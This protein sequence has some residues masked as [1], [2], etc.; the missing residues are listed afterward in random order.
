MHKFW[1]EYIDTFA[2]SAYSSRVDCSYDA[3]FLDRNDGYPKVGGI[4][5]NG[6][7]PAELG[8][9]QLGVSMATVFNKALKSF[10]APSNFAVSWVDD[11]ASMTWINKSGAAAVFKIWESKNGGEYTLVATTAAN[12]TSYNN[13]T[14]LN[15][16]MNFK[17]QAVN[18]A[19]ISDFSPVVNLATPLVIKSDQSILTTT[20]INAIEITVGKTVNINWDDGTNE[21]KTGPTSAT[22]NYSVEKNPYYIKLSGDTDSIT[23][24]SIVNQLKISCDISKWV[25]PLNLNYADLGGTNSTGN[26]EKLFSAPNLTYLKAD[27]NLT[28]DISKVVFSPSLTYIY[29]NQSLT[30]G[31]I[32]DA[33]NINLPVGLTYF[34]MGTPSGT[35]TRA[36]GDLSSKIIPLNLTAFYI[37]RQAFTKLPRGNYK[38]LDSAL[39]M[40]A[41]G[42]NCNTAEIDAFLVDVLAYFNGTAPYSNPVTPI[43][44]SKYLLNGTGMGIP[45][46]VGLAAKSAIEAKFTAA[47]FV[48]TITTN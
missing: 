32:G 23:K 2:N 3:I 13:Y 35:T 30:G 15:A 39:G 47:G 22:H 17:I 36:T 26:G 48:A 33:T 7:H 11:Y 28:A 16:N 24:L 19:W 29:I 46:S 45:S 31:I 38:N 41:N 14:W 18:G 42:N 37:V 20:C 40:Y 27:A 1:V 8:Y 10:I 6:V 25:M 44:S 9:D 21:N 34:A 12:A 43:K 4:H 5:T